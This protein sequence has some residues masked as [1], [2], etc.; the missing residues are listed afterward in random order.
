MAVERADHHES[1]GDGEPVSALVRARPHVNRALFW[2]DVEDV[3]AASRRE[4]PTRFHHV[5]FGGHCLWG[6]AEAHLPWLNS[7]LR[8]REHLDDKRIALSAIVPILRDLNA[9]DSVLPE[10]RAATARQRLLEDDLASYLAP[11]SPDPAE[12]SF[13]QR[14]AERAAAAAPEEQQAKA[15][16]RRF[17]DEIVADPGRLRDPS[18]LSDRAGISDL[19]NLSRWLQGDTDERDTRRAA[20]L[21][22][23]IAPAFSSE[24]A[25]AYRDG[26]S[27][28]WRLVPPQR[29]LRQEGGPI[30]TQWPNIL[31]FAGIGVEAAETPDWVSRLTSE[32]AALA[33][34]HACHSEEAYP[35][36]LGPLLDRHP[37]AV[38]PVIRQEIETEWQAAADYPDDLLRHFARSPGAIPERVQ[39]PLLELITSSEAPNIRKAALAI[40]I[41]QNMPLDDATRERIA[42][43]AA[44]RL[45]AVPPRNDDERVFLDLATLFLTDA[46]AALASLKAWIDAAAPGPDRKARSERALARLF[47]RD[48]ALV[49]GALRSLP[50]PMLSDLAHFTYV[51]VSPA[52]DIHHEGGYEHD[53]R[54]DAESA[55]SAIL[56]ALLDRPGEQAYLIVKHLADAGIAA[57]PPTRFRELARGKAE[58]DFEFEPW[59]P[60]QVVTM[61]TQHVAP[62][63]TSHDLIRVI[64]SVLKD[65]QRDLAHE[66]ASSRALLANADNENLVQNWL[67]EQLRL[68]TKGRYHV[69]REP[70]VAGKNEPDVVISAVGASVELA[71]EVKHGGKPWTVADLEHALAQQLAT[72]YLRT[73]ARRSGILVITNHRSR[74][75]RAPENGASLR[76]GPLISRLNGLAET[77]TSNPTGPIKVQVVGI[78]ATAAPAE[79]GKQR[80]AGL[81]SRGQRPN[82]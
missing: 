21:W 23:N 32:E 2:A 37:Q 18:R 19:L 36:W 14:A 81:K 56:R 22:H 60:R 41:L 7:D 67:A 53:I 28:L 76:F 30:T 74:T 12:T 15:S 11:P 38:L 44:A 65:I 34:S 77:L 8:T 29:P 54:D 55:R 6:F 26:M 64:A 73:Q 52:D 47:G 68:R 16:W 17:R 13:Q 66:D 69:H 80:D 31:A 5:H 43:N 75:W 45:N 78:D 9:L 40:D 27:R 61:E 63:R 71:I 57:I 10:L 25:E 1:R 46:G 33:S 70:E 50:T 62:I 79:E 72:D 82:K 42:R 3:R 58:R 59:R 20:L 39:Q 4:P 49:S 48:H 35:D 24:V 51:R